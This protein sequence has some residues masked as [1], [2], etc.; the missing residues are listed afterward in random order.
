MKIGFVVAMDKEY[1]PFLDKLGE[2][3]VADVV[4][5]IEFCSYVS[6]KGEVVLAKCG[7][8]EIA[9]SSA[10]SLLIGLYKVDYILNF[11]LVGALDE[12]LLEREI[13]AVESVVHYDSDLTPF[14]HPVGA[15]ADLPSPYVFSDPKLLSV[16]SEKNVRLVRLASGDKFIAD[17]V[18]KDQI[19]SDFSAGICDME[20]AGVAITAYRAKIPFTMIKVIS[21][22][23]GSDATSE[24][25]KNKNAGLVFALDVVLGAIFEVFKK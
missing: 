20:G 10:T 15:A 14:G 7:I 12:S 2:L 17:P 3:R 4:C 9:A 25:G 21:D 8:G 11:G 13:V 1:E 16:I 6:E 22:S 18:R 5:G 23:A 19:V 24:Y